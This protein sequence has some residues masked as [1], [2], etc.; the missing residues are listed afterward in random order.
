MQFEAVWDKL[1]Y[2]YIL[3]NIVKEELCFWDE[4]NAAISPTS[5]QYYSIHS[6]SLH[7]VYLELQVFPIFRKPAVFFSQLI[8]RNRSSVAWRE[9]IL[10]SMIVTELMNKLLTLNETRRFTIACYLI[11]VEFCEQ[12]DHSTREY[13]PCQ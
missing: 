3:L 6:F 8:F 13:G 10:D 1:I 9:I 7:T 11:V 4:T 5:N 12:F 2:I